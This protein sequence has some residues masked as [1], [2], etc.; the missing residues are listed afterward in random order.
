MRPAFWTCLDH[1]LIAKLKRLNLQQR[2]LVL[3]LAAN[4]STRVPGLVGVLFF[5]PRLKAA[6][7]LE[8]FATLMASIALGGSVTFAMNG[9]AIVT[10]R[11]VGESASR[12][13]RVGEADAVRSVFDVA[14]IGVLICSLVIIGYGW[15]RGSTVQ[16]YVGALITALTA[17]TQQQD[18]VRVAYNEHY[19]TA[20]ILV[21]VQSAAYI[22][23]LLILPVSTYSILLGIAVII[24]PVI[25]SSIISLMALLRRRPYLLHGRANLRRLVARQG[26]MFGLSEGLLMA[27]LSFVVLYLDFVGAVA[28]S[29]W[30]ATTLRLF[31][32]VLVP[33]VLIL[34][35]LSSY[36]RLIWN[37]CTPHRRQVIIFS[38]LFISLAYSFVVGAAM[39]MLS[40]LYVGGTMHIPEP[41]STLQIAAIAGMFAAVVVFKSYTSVSFVV[42][43]SRWLSLSLV[44]G[45]LGAIGV[46]LLA[47]IVLTPI[48]AVAVFAAA[49]TLGI[50]T[51]TTIDAI[52]FRRTATV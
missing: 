41:G 1:I 9:V 52:R 42:L 37:D 48:G 16:F 51:S 19:I 30:F 5:L 13:D 14:L 24:G 29:A 21:A 44:V 7:G 46:G 8:A 2:K 38:T 3:S 43:D 17:L 15:A 40:R 22:L 31:M 27:S 34:M 47:S 50:V 25:A 45:T 12:N 26:L 18:A 32:V 11:E 36:I 49:L 33:V 39:I 4:I 35:P 6:I 10:R 23:V 20:T 28:D